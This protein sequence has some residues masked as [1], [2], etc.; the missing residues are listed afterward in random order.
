[1]NYLRECIE[2]VLFMARGR[3]IKEMKEPTAFEKLKNPYS[4]RDIVEKM[5]KTI[6]KK[7]EYMIS[8]GNLKS[9][10]G[11]DLLQASGYS[12]VADKLNPYRFLSHFRA[13]H[14]GS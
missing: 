5:A 13:V 14:R 6:G 12:I 3:V 2:D 9:R 11:L 10:T 8:T 7:M 1:M 4:I